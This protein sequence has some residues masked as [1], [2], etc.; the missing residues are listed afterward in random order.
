MKK[1]IIGI[2]AGGLL[3]AGCSSATDSTETMEVVEEVQTST[4]AQP[5]V[6]TP[7]TGSAQPGVTTP[8]AGCSETDEGQ[9]ALI[10]AVMVD[11][12]TFG[13]TKSYDADGVTYI[14][15]QIHRADGGITS[16][17]D[18]FALKES[19]LVPLTSS[20]RSDSDLPDG[21]KA[22]GVSAS[23]AGAT[24]AMDCARTY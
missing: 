14:A 24:A 7:Q 11:G 2:A 12:K 5:G 21:R 8:A 15:G 23:D 4:A 10:N 17:D 6:T 20:A 1:I 13:E 9:L 22:L 3:L 19:I 18:V 16:R